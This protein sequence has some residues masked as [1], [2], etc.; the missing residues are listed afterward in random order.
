MKGPMLWIKPG[1]VCA[2]IGVWKGDGADKI[3]ACQPSKLHLIDPWE[4]QDYPGRVYSI[5][6]KDLDQIYLDVIEKYKY[7]DTVEVHR[8]F[9][10]EIKFPNE[11]FDWV[12]IDGNHSCETVMAD[13][14]RFWPFVKTGGIL[15]GDDYGWNDPKSSGG[16][17]KA[18]N[19]FASKMGINFLVVPGDQF[20]FFK[21]A[22]NDSIR[23]LAQEHRRRMA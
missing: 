1:F 20:I 9:S 13:L 19:D 23:E 22:P 21:G 11:Y 2:E 5:E 4:F 15:C 18:V 10:Q 12:Y 7:N 14:E 17:K 3:L 8:E 6:Q 16:P